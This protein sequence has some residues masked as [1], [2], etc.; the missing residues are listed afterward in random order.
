M[1]KKTLEDYIQNIKNGQDLINR[2][3]VP[4]DSTKMMAIVTMERLKAIR[5]R[6]KA[7]IDEHT[8]GTWVNAIESHPSNIGPEITNP[9]LIRNY[10]KSGMRIEATRDVGGAKITGKKGRIISV[11]RGSPQP[12]QI[13]FDNAIKGR[14]GTNLGGSAKSGHGWS[15]TKNDFKLI[16]D[17]P[18]VVESGYTLAEAVIADE[19]QGAMV[20]F[21]KDYEGAMWDR[22]GDQIYVSKRKI[23]KGT[24]GK[25]LN[26]QAGNLLIKLSEPVKEIGKQEY[27]RVK[28]KDV[29]DTLEASNLGPHLPKNRELEIFKESLQQFLPTAV[30]DSDTAEEIIVALLAGNKDL[31]FYGPWG[32]GK[33]FTGENILEVAKEQGVL[34]KE[35]D[36]QINCNPFSIFDENYA[37]LVPPC[38]ECME[39]YDRNY[40]ETGVFHPPRPED[41]EVQVVKLDI[42]FGIQT[43]EGTTKMHRVDMVGVKLP[44]FS[45]QVNKDTRSLDGFRYGFLPKSNNGYFLIE[46]ADKLREDTHKNLLQA[47]NN[48]RVKPDETDFYLPSNQLMILTAN[49]IAAFGPAENDRFVFIYIG[50]P[51]DPDVAYDIT[52]V[53]YHKEP[54]PMME[55]D[56]EDPH[57]KQ[58][59]GTRT[60]QI[61]VI[62]EKA[63][64][65]FYINFDSSYKGEGKEVISRS[66]RSK[67]D[68]HDAARSKWMVHKQFID[69]TPAFPDEEFVMEGIKYAM[70]WRVQ[71]QD[72]ESC[73]KAKDDLTKFIFKE[74]P[75]YV[76]EEAKKWW[77]DV[78]EDIATKI[79]RFP[80]IKEAYTQEIARYHS[81]PESAID[82]FKEVKQAYLHPHDAKAKEALIKNPFMD[83]LFESQPHFQTT[84][85]E[86][87]PG[88]VEYLIS[89]QPKMN[90]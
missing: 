65:A 38:S 47:Q 27:V 36:C 30:L 78:N 61:P 50:Y 69:E 40:K 37:K 57:L 60:V 81:N 75:K 52:K 41:V 89:F 90:K 1:K 85:V 21:S 46:E 44:D 3:V 6:L 51:T 23:P 84:S 88:L 54:R 66:T 7:G 87:V 83:L 34:I 28:V 15:L 14:T 29:Y 5:D 31:G 18:L 48:Q 10:A 39:K 35:K 71:D 22:N 32:G 2:G 86:Q 77:C 58:P 11:S 13:E 25:L 24:L 4:K 17:K 56:I 59:N 19:R 82:S 9:S 20:R 70:W 49:D 45:G 33:S 26:E 42:G 63:I 73:L 43:A 67:F 53:S 62:L 72:W 8:L 12:Y 79:P 68:A 55:L 76:T 74:F 64:E 16:L 80:G